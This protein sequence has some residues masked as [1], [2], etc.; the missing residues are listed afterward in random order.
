[1]MPDPLD[2]GFAAL[3]NDVAGQLLAPQLQRY[4]YAGEL[5]AMR[6]LVDAHPPA[7]WSN[8]LYTSWLSALR[9]LSPKGQTAIPAVAKTEAWNRRILNTQLASW[10]QL[11]HDTILYAKQ[12][13]TGGITCE[14]PDAYVDPYPEFFEGIAA[15]ARLGQ[16]LVIDL[17]MPAQSGLNTSVLAYF[18]QLEATAT[19]LRTMAEHQQAGMPFTAEQMAFVNDAVV[20]KPEYFQD[21][22]Q[23]WYSKLFFNK[24]SAVS[25]DPPVADVHTAPTDENG[26][27]VGEV[28]HV[29]TGHARLMVV[30]AETCTGPKAYVGVASSYFETVTQ[31]FQ[32]LD[33]EAWVKKLAA[34]VKPAEV[35]WMMDLVAPR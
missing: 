33:D 6:T 4:D 27:P 15:F 28:L 19:L 2:V 18:K 10:A 12:S 7:F 5:H 30:T 23:G 20:T 24:E 34:P 16:K 8:T 25:Y 31:K 35:P 13:Y 1:M 14:F 29:G 3:A 11:R 9:Q 32:R 22:A 26:N 17:E 21:V